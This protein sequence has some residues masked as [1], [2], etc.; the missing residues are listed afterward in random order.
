LRK[1]R[2]IS[3]DKIRK[4]AKSRGIK[5]GKKEKFPQIRKKCDF[6]AAGEE[7]LVSEKNTEGIFDNDHKKRERSERF[8]YR[9]TIISFVK[10][11]KEKN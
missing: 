1:K 11:E 7:T 8:L 10:K 4:N 3:A 2:K 9:D 6:L 5:C